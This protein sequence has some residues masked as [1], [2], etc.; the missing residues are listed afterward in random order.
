SESP[1]EVS[2]TNSAQQSIPNNT[3][4]GV[5]FDTILPGLTNAGGLTSISGQLKLPFSGFYIVQFSIGVTSSA[6]GPY[7]LYATINDGEEEYGNDGDNA[8]SSARVDLCSI[9]CRRFSA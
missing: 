8:A 7:N 4:T 5:L 2:A 3:V 6:A 1:Y 9:L